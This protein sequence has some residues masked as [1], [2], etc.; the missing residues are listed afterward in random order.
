MLSGLVRQQADDL[1]AFWKTGDKQRAD[2]YDKTR[3]A[4]G[5]ASASCWT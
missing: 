5:K 2:K 3:K 1:Q 4:A